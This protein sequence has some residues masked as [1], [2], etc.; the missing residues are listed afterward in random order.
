[1]AGRYP[2][3]IVVD[4]T[5]LSNFASTDS[6]SFLIAVLDS[7]MVVPAVRDELKRG[8]DTGHD[9]LDTAVDALSDE[10]PVRPLSSDRD[11]QHIRE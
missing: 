1:M 5:V 10:L 4:T 7:P 11:S 3:P 9:Y 8:L 2:Q 6:I